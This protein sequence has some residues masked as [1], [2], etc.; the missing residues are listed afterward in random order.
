MWCP[1]HNARFMAYSA[2]K[3]LAAR[4]RDAI[5]ALPHEKLPLQMSLFPRGACGDASLLLGAYL[6][7]CGH[8]GFEYVSAVRG[9]MADSTWTTHAWL[10]R[11]D[12]VIDIT[13]DQF[14]DAPAGVIVDSPSLWHQQFDAAEG[15]PSDFRLWNGPGISHLVSMYSILRPALFR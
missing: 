7:D 9:E 4:M 1:R 2:L 15:E 5:I 11:G 8:M 3:L 10:A 12:L 13:A 6:I 14:P